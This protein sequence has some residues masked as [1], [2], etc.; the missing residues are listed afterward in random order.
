MPR[1]ES[2]RDDIF[3]DAL[4]DIRSAREPSS[5][6]D[7]STSDEVSAPSKFEYE[8]WAN[9]PMSVQERRQRFLKGMGFDEFVSTRMDSFQCHGEITIVDS[10]TDMEE[11]TV[12]GIASLD[13]SV[14][15]NELVF[16][17]TSGIRDLDIGK[18]CIV[19][20]GVHTSLTDM[21]KEVGSDKVMSLL[22][23][24]SLLGLSR[25]VQKL[26]RRGCG[27][28]HTREAKG[29]KKKDVKSLWK[30]FMTKKSFGGICKYD[31]QVKNCTTG[32]P[33][34]TR[35]QHRKKKFVEFSAVYMD[36]E[37]RAHK[38][39]INVMKFSPSGWYLASGGEDCVAR[40]WQITEVK[41]SPKL[42]AG[43]DPYEDVE[44][45][46]VLK[47]KLVKGQSHALAVIPK[48]TFHI[49]EIPLHEF[50]G[51]TSDILDL[52]WSK[53]DYILTSSKD[54]T[55]RLWK[56]GCDGCLAV[57]KHTDYV[58]CVQFNP[59][60]ERYFISGSIDCKV[61]I[62]DI[63]DK[64]VTDWADTR[65]IITALSYQPDG[66]GFIVGT[67]TGVCRFYDQSGE[68]I[69][70]EKELFVQ[71]KK[72]SAA[73]RIN[74]LKLCTSDSQRIIITSTDS[75]IRVADGDI[76]QKFEGPWKSKAL[77]SPS[78]TSDGRYL[79]SAGKDSN[80][81]IWNF[82]NSGDAKSVHACE[83]FFSKDV[84]TAVPW[85][86]VNQDGHIKPPCLTEKSVSAP[87]LLL[88]G[89]CRSPGPWSFA[90]G[91]RGSATWPEEKLLSAKPE[92]GPQLGD[93]L[94]VISAAWN[95]VIVTA[96]R[97]GVIRSFPNY[98]LPVRL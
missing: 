41:A 95:T 64:R 15:D 8:I 42:Y 55:V 34:R 23:F 82:P 49:S 36:Q 75:K 72:K 77:S 67:L 65:N 92:N 81:Y 91:K 96:S 6:E 90:D 59:I 51:H 31:V 71:G 54:K 85:L 11:R 89:E 66:K 18:R 13:S 62:W 26:L 39:S 56:A 2:D 86:G 50:H 70:L 97:D 88:H 35:V 46:K 19:Q 60:D 93:C 20:N 32:I 87:T 14:C 68:N 12:S 73:S 78:L 45:V 7:C 16:D 27:K 17:S 28:S 53:S 98:G 33:S 84:T 94:S 24:E 4:E 58:T 21:V 22:E 43:D 61:R 74:S 38:G 5:S 80:V 30:K 79:V 3:F 37:I 29:V 52:T 63:L 69:Q 47:T 1:S 10:F 40:I 48:K 25:S 9:E 83:L 44:K 57:F 76:V